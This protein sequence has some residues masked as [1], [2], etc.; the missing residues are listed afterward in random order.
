[1]E[2]SPQRWALG[3]EYRGI[4]YCGWQRQVGQ[5]SVQQKLE[6]ALSKIAMTPISVVAA[7][8]T[9]T[10]VHASLQVVHFE[11]RVVRD[12]LAWV[13]GGNQFLPDDIAIR[14]AVPVDDEFHAR[15]AATSRRYVYLLASQPHRP[16]LNRGHVGWTHW[17]LEV[18]RIE[19]ALPALWGK[20]DFTSFRA[21]ECQAK[22]PIKTIYSAKVEQRGNVLRF[23][24]HADA[25]LH[26]M[27]R[28]IVGA[29]VYIG[30]SR[31]PCDWLKTLIAQKD[32]TLAAPTFSPD[33]LYLAGIEYDH[34]F[35]LPE[36]LVDPCL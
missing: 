18:S 12:A 11:T 36:A 28:N 3:L 6:E 33:G 20:H 35:A 27:I 34:R 4:A 9:D 1:M 32:R 23:D 10:G 19:A 24:F 29:L 13:R 2:K 15:F 21:S 31:Q 22:S 14:W 5:P 26:H 30:N 8:R 25:F 17:P 7:G 16:G